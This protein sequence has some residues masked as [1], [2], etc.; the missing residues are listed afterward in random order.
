MGLFDWLRG[1]KAKVQMAENRIWLSRQAK[2]AG[3]QREIAQALGDPNGHDAV[4]V[5]AHFQDCLDELRSLVAGAGFDEGR[6]L[7]TC[8]EALEG[9]TAGTASDESRRVFIAVGDS[10]CPTTDTSPANR[11]DR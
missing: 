4:F 1:P 7:V 3:I 6:V 11:T 10:A 5:V 2:F 9:R 8:S